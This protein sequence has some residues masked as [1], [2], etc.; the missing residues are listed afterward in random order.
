MTYQQSPMNW[1]TYS[2]KTTSNAQRKFFAS[3]LSEIVL[4]ENPAASQNRKSS[5]KKIHYSQL[6][7]YIDFHIYVTV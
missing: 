2:I 1:K 3:E 5:T 6:V 7:Y 4:E